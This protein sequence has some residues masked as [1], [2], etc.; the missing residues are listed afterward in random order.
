MKPLHLISSQEPLGRCTAA[1]REQRGERL[2]DERNYKVKAL[3]F[4]PETRCCRHSSAIKWQYCSYPLPLYVLIYGVP[5]DV[6]CMF[7]VFVF[8]AVPVIIKCGGQE[9]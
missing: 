8:S 9:S 7:F 5:V 1:R 6:P 3:P 2:T 4:V